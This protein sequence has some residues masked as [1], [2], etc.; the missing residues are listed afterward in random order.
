MRRGEELRDV[1]GREG[2]V[3]GAGGGKGVRDKRLIRERLEY[4]TRRRRKRRTR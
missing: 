1:A 3:E 2:G 4:R